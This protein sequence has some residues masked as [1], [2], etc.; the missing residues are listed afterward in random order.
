VDQKQI[1]D[2]GIKAGAKLTLRDSRDDHNVA[3]LTVDDVYRPDKYVQML[4]CF[5]GILSP[6]CVLTPK[7]QGQGSQ[8]GLW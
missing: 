3:I 5:F 2:L 8:G 1:D 6:P 7:I 4:G